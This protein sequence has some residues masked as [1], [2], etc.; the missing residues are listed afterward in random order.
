MR[1]CGDAGLEED[2]KQRSRRGT[3]EA[4]AAVADDGAARRL[5][6]KLLGPVS[7]DA[8]AMV[9]ELWCSSG[10]VRAVF[11]RNG[12]AMLQREA[13]VRHHMQLPPQRSHAGPCLHGRQH[14]RWPNVARETRT[15]SSVYVGRLTAPR[16][17]YI[18][19]RTR[20]MKFESVWGD[21]GDRG[22]RVSL[23]RVHSRSH[24]HRQRWQRRQWQRRQNGAPENR[25]PPEAVPSRAR[26]ASKLARVNPRRIEW[27]TYSGCK[28]EHAPATRCRSSMPRSRALVTW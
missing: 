20:F 13:H 14:Q 9:F 26:V 10:G 18:S 8:R 15:L 3:A 21:E 23:Q 19:E 27:P 22:Q 28:G 24:S 5:S 25:V 16:A 2:A 12:R 1:G 17:A 11:Q 6:S 7:R 4:E